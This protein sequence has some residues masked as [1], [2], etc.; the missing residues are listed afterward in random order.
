LNKLQGNKPLPFIEV[1]CLTTNARFRLYAK[2]TPNANP[3][4]VDF[5]STL[6]FARDSRLLFVGNLKK[7]QKERAI[8]G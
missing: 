7:P 3:N 5:D 4:K 1:T 8:K 6:A 2:E